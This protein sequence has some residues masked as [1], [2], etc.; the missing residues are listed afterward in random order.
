MLLKII[1]V[2]ETPEYLSAS[3]YGA[4]TGVL[5]FL[6]INQRDIVFH[7]I[8]IFI[9]TYEREIYKYLLQEFRRSFS[10]LQGL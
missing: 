1:Q 7:V 3:M 9:Y 10:W 6:H 5:E 2:L 4:N 8:A